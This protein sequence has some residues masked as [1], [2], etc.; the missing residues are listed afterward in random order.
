M[1]KLLLLAIVTLT[2]AA[3]GQDSETNS[4][5]LQDSENTSE[6]NQDLEETDSQTEG[7]QSY[8]DQRFGVSFDYPEDW[9]V[10]I[11]EEKDQIEITSPTN[12]VT[13]SLPAE[14]PAEFEDANT[15]FLD[16]GKITVEENSPIPNNDQYPTKEY[17][18]HGWLIY[19]IDFNG[20]YIKVGSEQY[21]NE[22]EQAAVKMILDTLE[23][24][25]DF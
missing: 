21:L 2:F 11:N 13:V 23:V 18:Q 9:K 16:S 6:E 17:A 22:A 25:S 3:C 8:S 4:D 24:S 5:D 20:T 12:M 7:T 15:E 19:L 10:G 1:K 14:S